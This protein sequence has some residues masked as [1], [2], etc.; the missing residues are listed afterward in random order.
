MLIR[1]D[2]SVLLLVD[3][4]E[5]LQPAIHEAEKVL[6]ASVWLTR[7]AQRLA[8]P[9]ICTEQYPQGLGPT[10]PALRRL[11]PDD[12]VVEKIH[13]SAVAEGALFRTAGGDRAQFVVAGT[14]A[15]VCVQQTVLDLIAAGRR[16]FVVDEAVG[17]RR[18][19]DKALALERMRGHGADIVSREMVAFEWLRQAGTDLFRGISREFLR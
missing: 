12:C 11:L 14:E 15:H 13:F 8:I 17:S 10:M 6:E 3:L 18:S 9:V 19:A 4:Q 7:V 2:R 1:T 16:V 5:R